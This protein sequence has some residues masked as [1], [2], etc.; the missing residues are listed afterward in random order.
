M[1]KSF[2]IFLI[3]IS[4]LTVFS[5][6]VINHEDIQL[7]GKLITNLSLDSIIFGNPKISNTIL[8]NNKIVF[9]LSSK[10]EGYWIK[11]K[12]VGLICMD[13]TCKFV[14]SF[15][16]YVV[17]YNPSDKELNTY[18]DKSKVKPI[19]FP[20]EFYLNDKGKKID[21]KPFNWYYKEWKN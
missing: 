1:I 18:S 8:S 4:N 16:G 9:N 6:K 19:I 20:D 15:R 13:S 5:Q 11:S 21:E 10:L 14:S 2:C 7:G 12:I 3:F 17:E